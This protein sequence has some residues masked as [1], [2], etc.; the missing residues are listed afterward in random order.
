[1]SPNRGPSPAEGGPQKPLREL[2][3]VNK[4]SVGDRPAVE[5]EAGTSVQITDNAEAQPEKPRRTIRQIREAAQSKTQ[6][7]HDS[8]LTSLPPPPVPPQKKKSSI[9]GGLFQVREPTQLALNQVAAQMVAQHGSTSATKVPNVRLEK[10]PEFVPKVNSKWDGIPE[11]AKQKQ[12]KEKERASASGSRSNRPRAGS[13]DTRDGERR[14][15]HSRNSSST[16]DSF[17]S[18]GRSS[19]SHTASGRTR[20]SVPSANS[21]GDLASQ[22][23][24]DR[25]L[26]PTEPVGTPS[27]FNQSKA[28][29]AESLP[30]VSADPREVKTILGPN[31][32]SN[33]YPDRESNRS[34][35]Y[36]DDQTTPRWLGS[37]T[38]QPTPSIQAVPAH[39]TSPMP[40]PQ[41]LSPVKPTAFD[42]Q[43]SRGQTRSGMPQQNVALTSSGVGVLRPPAVSKTKIPNAST[44][45]FLAGEA[46][47]LTIPDNKTGTHQ[48]NLPSHD[49]EE[50]RRKTANSAPP[51]SRKQKDL[52]KRPDSSR[53]RLG[54]QASM[55]V[56]EEEEEEASPWQVQDKEQASVSSPKAKAAIAS[57]RTASSPRTKFNRPFP[58]F[59]K[60]KDK[61]SA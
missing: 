57:S 2:E 27:S 51:S 14:S 54:L 36:T 7:K 34:K 17:A 10:M 56:E 61:S 20:F 38:A 60:D 15:L 50:G 16:T 39:S 58:F 23:R 44:N 8:Q 52:E 55:L 43:L 32:A 28:N 13:R 6:A 37:S 12:K 42:P 4:P 33:R 48:A 22:R 25:S 30:E 31:N 3:N 18:R 21:S 19:G 45:G 49:R 41:E 35:A 53:A 11:S 5:E 47:E 26:A 40:T 9:L 59:G 24:V 1:M 46:Q 29:S